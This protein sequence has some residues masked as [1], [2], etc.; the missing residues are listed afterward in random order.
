MK[1][2]NKTQAYTHGSSK[3]IQP[4]TNP[5][6]STSQVKTIHNHSLQPSTSN[7]DSQDKALL[8]QRLPTPPHHHHQSIR[9][10]P[11]S[12]SNTPQP[13]SR[14][15]VTPTWRLTQEP[16]SKCRRPKPNPNVR[17]AKIGT[18]HLCNNR[19]TQARSRQSLAQEPDLR[20]REVAQAASRTALSI[21]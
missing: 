4:I 6:S 1:A 3:N 17:K 14:Q 16:Q 2:S 10:T 20:S 8:L 11:A 15:P 7:I 21:R 9:R 13:A 18:L 5:A 19:L 12:P